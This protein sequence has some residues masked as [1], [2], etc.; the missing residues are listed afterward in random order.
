MLQNAASDLGLHRLLRPVCPN[1]EDC[2]GNTNCLTNILIVSFIN[3]GTN[4]NI[5]LALYQ[6]INYK[7][8]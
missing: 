8:L 3:F 1:T 7:L 4:L 6:I 5:K 2:Y